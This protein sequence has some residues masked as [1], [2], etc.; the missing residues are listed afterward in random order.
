MPQE[1]S[2][3]RFPR[4]AI[5]VPFLYTTH[6]PISPTDRRVGWTRSLSEGGATVELSERLRPLTPIRLRLQSDRGMIEAEAQVV[7]GGGRAQEG[8]GVVHGVTFTRMAPDHAQAL[9]SMFRPLPTLRRAGIRLPLD[10]P[11]TCRPKS[12]P[13]PPVPGRTRNVDRGGLL[14]R[15]PRLL[16]AGTTLEVALHGPG[17]PL[18]VDGSVAWVEPHEMWTPGESIGHGFRFTRLDWPTALSLGLLL[19]E[20]VQP[21]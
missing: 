19:V 14:L 8:G 11:A 10:L 9:R 2:R 21:A 18:T 1:P 20:A 17:E 7:W 15:L 3:R 13:G 12:P 4:L 5:H 16:P 6:A